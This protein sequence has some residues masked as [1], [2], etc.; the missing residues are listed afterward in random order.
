MRRRF[1]VSIR[2]NAH[3]KIWFLDLGSAQLGDW[4]NAGLQ[5]NDVHRCPNP[6][7]TVLAPCRETWKFP[8]PHLILSRLDICL[9]HG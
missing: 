1:D 2:Y 4:A 5:P 6:I 3:G 9:T 7:M 8:V